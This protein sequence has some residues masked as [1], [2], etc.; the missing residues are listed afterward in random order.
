MLYINSYGYCGNGC[1]LSFEA[2]SWPNVTSSACPFGWGSGTIAK[3]LWRSLGRGD[4][5]NA[6]GTGSGRGRFWGECAMY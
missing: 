3:F 4:L 1:E 2:G 5:E 6:R